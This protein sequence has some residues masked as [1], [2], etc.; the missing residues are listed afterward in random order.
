MRR[1]LPLPLFICVYACSNTTPSQQAQITQ[2]LSVICNVDG[3]LVPVAQPVVASVGPNGAA[4]VD[5]DSLLVHP[6]VVAACAS[7]KGTPVSVTSVGAS[8]SK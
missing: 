5:V 3:V 7:L 4:A 6:A 8:S 2:A 1:I